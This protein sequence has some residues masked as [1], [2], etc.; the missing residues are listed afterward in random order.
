MLNHVQP[1]LLLVPEP[2][3]EA[4]WPTL[5]NF[6]GIKAMTVKRRG[7]M[8]RHKIVSFTVRKVGRRRHMTWKSRN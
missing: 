6:K 4:H 2:G 5:L 7:N 8:V 3:R 1:G